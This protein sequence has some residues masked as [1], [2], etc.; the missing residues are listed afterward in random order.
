MFALAKQLQGDADLTRSPIY[1]V[2]VD[3]LKDNLHHVDQ[4]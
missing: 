4:N 3:L 2:I 1:P